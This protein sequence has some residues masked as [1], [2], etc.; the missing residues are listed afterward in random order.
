MTCIV[1]IETP[2]G[3]LLAGDTRVVWPNRHA[4]IDTK[5]MEMRGAAAG[6]AG[7]ARVD[8][9]LKILGEIAPYKGE[10]PERWIVTCFCP[11]LEVALEACKKQT[12][13]LVVK[14]DEAWPIESV[15]LVAVG[16]Q[17]WS[18]DETLYAMRSRDGYDAVGSGAEYAIGALYAT[19]ATDV[20]SDPVKRAHVAIEA[21]AWA[22]PTVGGPI[23]HTHV[24]RVP[25]TGRKK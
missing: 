25:K 23:T 12:K 9:L 17:I 11:V 20:E 7:D 5:L 10:D 13:I 1:G 8:Q 4:A 2:T 21:A 3:A 14:D 6:F 18:V 22:C 19:K 16:G 15:C 24:P